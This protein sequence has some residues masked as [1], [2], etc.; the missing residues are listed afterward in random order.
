MDSVPAVQAVC[1]CTHQIKLVF[2]ARPGSPPFRAVAWSLDAALEWGESWHVQG[3]HL[4]SPARFAVRKGVEELG[5]GG[6]AGDARQPV[7]MRQSTG[8]RSDL[9]P[10]LQRAQAEHGYLSPESVGRIARHLRV[11]DNEVYGVAS[12][13]AQFRFT[14]PGRHSLRVCLG[15][16]CH[17]KGGVQMLETLE[18]RLGV[19]PGETTP[20][21]EYDL[22]R[23]ACLGCC[24]LAPVFSLD[25][26]IYGQM[27]VLKLQGILDG[28][29]QT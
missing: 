13:Y 19:A 21:G 16:A 17:V 10:M 20:D 7:I 22:E 26:T 6:P 12:F 23:V 2:L 14:P 28:H 29:G 8:A 27:S 25:K 11:T 18:R 5:R 15:T 3:T 1:P 9:V 4:G 24:A